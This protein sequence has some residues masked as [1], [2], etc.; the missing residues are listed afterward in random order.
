MSKEIKLLLFN[1]LIITSVSGVYSQTA[2]PSDNNN[3]YYEIDINGPKE[4]LNL[5]LSVKELEFHNSNQ[6]EL[7]I[8]PSGGWADYTYIIKKNNVLITPTPGGGIITESEGQK[9]ITGLS[10][11]VYEVELRDDK[12]SS[13]LSCNKVVKQIE[14][15]NPKLLEINASVNLGIPCNGGDGSIKVIVKGG[16]APASGNYTIKLYK[17]SG[18]TPVKTAYL[19]HSKDTYKQIIFY[20]LKNG[21][22]KVTVNDKYI[23]KFTTQNL[24]QPSVLDLPSSNIVTT[25]V[26]CFGDSNGTIKVT[27]TGGTSPYK[28]FLNGVE[29]PGA[30]TGTKIIN[31]KKAANNYTILI[32]DGNK[33][34]TTL[35]TGITIGGPSKELSISQI[36]Q[37]NTTSTGASDGFVEYRINGGTSGYTYTFKGTSLTGVNLSGSIVSDGGTVKFEGL[38]KDNYIFK[39]VDKTTVCTKSKAVAITDPDVLEINLTKTD[40]K[41]FGESTGTITA[42]VKGGASNVYKYKWYKTTASGSII[43]TLSDTGSSI[44]KGVGYYKVEVKVIYN[45]KTVETK[46]SNVAVIDQPSENL[47]IV[48]IIKNVSCKGGND[49]EIN[50]TNV[51]G[52]TPPY[53]YLWSN[54]AKTKNISG[55]SKG[56]YKVVV[57]DK[58]GCTLEETYTVGEPINELTITLDNSQDPLS[59]NGTDGRINVSVTG[60]NGTYT[61]KWTNKLGVNVGTSQDLSGVGAGKYT[62]VVTDAKGCTD[63]LVE[64]PLNQPD[65]LVPTI[66]IPSDGVLFCNGDNDGKLEVSVVGGLKPY[67]YHWYEILSNGSKSFLSGKTNSSV[68]GLSAGKYGIQITDRNGAGIK[69]FDEITLN[70]PNKVVLGTPTITNVK[71]KGQSTGAIEINAVGGANNYT[72]KWFKE[73]SSVVFSTLKKIENQKAG[74]YKV[75]VQD[76]NNC[77]STP[78]EATI[79]ITEPLAELSISGSSTTDASGFGLLNGSVNVTVS[80]G[81]SPY[82]YSLKEKSTGI[83]KGTSNNVTGLAGSVSGIVYE[84][85]ITDSQ[86]CKLIKEYTIYQPEKLELSL[87]LNS[88]IRCNGEDGSIS[89]TVTG[90]FLTAGSSYDYKWY[91]KLNLT[92]VIGTGVGLTAKAGDYRL[93]VEDSKGNTA[94]QDYKL[95]ENAEVVLSYTK[96]DVNCYGGNDGSIDLTVVG[97]TGVYTYIWSNGKKTQDLSSITKGVYKVVVSDENGCT[98]EVTVTISE[99][100][101]GLSISGSNT[102]DASGF[103]LLNGSV[104]VTVSGGTPPYTYSLKEK[105]TGVEKGTSNNVTGLAGSVSGIVYEMTIT[106][107]QGCKLIKEYT[108]YQP[109][110][111]ELSLSLNSEIRCNGEDGSISSTV[112][113]GFLTAGSSYDYKWYNK[114][115]LTKVIGTGVGLTT[116]A[117]DYRLIVEDSKGNTAFQDYKLKENAEVVLS[118]TKTDVNC[119]GGND[120]S[121]DLTVVGGTGVYTYIWSNGKKTQ[122]LSNITKGVYKVVV[123]DENGCRKEETITITE[124]DEYKI[125]TDVFRRPTGAG[126]SDGEITVSV[127]GGTKPYTFKWEN[128]KGNIISTTNSILNI[129][130]GI[131]KLQVLDKKGCELNQVFNLGEPEKL[132]ISIKETSSIQCHGDLSG[133]LELE[134]T[135]GVG[136]NTYTWYNATTNAVIGNTVSI[137]NLGAES[138]YVKVVDANGIDAT[139]TVYNLTEPTLLTATSSFKNLSCF[140]SKDGSIELSVKGGT[141]GYFYRIKKGTNAY[142]TWNSFAS[143]V[144]IENLSSD[145]YQ[146]Q[147]KDSND[148]YLTESGGIKVLDF[149]I[150]QPLLLEVKETIT[151]VSGFGLSNG[152]I[153]L[154]VSGGTKPYVYSWTDVSGTIVSLTKDLLN[155]KAGTYTLA[156]R[157][158]NNCEVNVSYKVNEPEKLLISIKETSSI[159]CHGDLSGVLELETTGGVGGNTYTWYNATTNAVIGNTVSISNLGAESYYVKVVDANGIDATSTVYNLT[160][161]TLLTA[162]SSFK[163]LSCFESKDG[164]IELS[165]KGGT[166]GYFYRIKKGTNA[167][168]TWN[169]FASTVSIENLS[170]DSYQVQIKD[171]N[172]CYLTES[173]GIKV[174]DFNITQ[175]LLLEVKETI[176]DVSGFGLSNGKIALNVSG[177]TK[178]YVYSWTDVS[179]TIVSLTKDLL[180]VKAGTYTLALRDKNNCEVNVSYKVNEPDKLLVN[181]K[182][183]NIVFC[184]GDKGASIKSI[185]AGGIKPYNYFWYDSNNT[186]LSNGI[187]LD[188]IGIGSY[189]LQVTDSKGNKTKSANIVVSQPDVLEVTIDGTPG[190]CGTDND[191]LITANVTGGTKP[192]SYF[193]STGAKTKELKNMSLGSYFVVITDAN[194]CKT[195]KNIVLKNPSPLKVTSKVTNVTCYNTCTGKVEL[196]VEGGLAPYNIVWNTGDTG[197]LITNACHGTYTATITDKKGCTIVKSIIVKNVEEF[198]FDIVPDEVTLC[199]GETI[200]YDVTMDGVSKYTWTSDNGF[201]S[202]KSIVTLSEGGKYTLT[203]TT[204]EGCLVSRNIEIF[205]SDVKID[206]QLILTS[207]AFVNED[208]VII[209]VSNPISSNTEWKI[210]SNVTI[211]QKTIEGLVLRFP[212]PGNYDLSLIATEGNCKKIATKT[213]NVL[214][215]RDLSDVGDSKNPFIK[216][217]EVYSNPNK[218]KFKVDVELEKEAEISLRLYSLSANTVIV[219][220]HLKGKKEYTIEYDMNTSVGVYVLLLETPKGKRIRKVIIK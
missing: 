149:N 178:P 189:Y 204:K 112:T 82:T 101:A 120:G 186:L 48:K 179:G 159:Q 23:Q 37:G 102:T 4:K 209:N 138:Y 151:D 139:S 84:M 152:K 146:V 73:G 157:D 89:S 76:I 217:F 125:V 35:K 156:L 169:S 133:V 22:Y 135:G 77:P 79:T 192:Y 147:I 25:K 54:N 27:P 127:I 96:T 106:D 88:E 137:S 205:K 213:V 98:K 26:T 18:T 114:L 122:D 172:D 153:A 64:V 99:P 119:Y 103:G 188:N 155:V 81:T 59:F 39:I 66:N 94:F 92:K 215:A 196:E 100:T 9:T 15:K 123:S 72:Y 143:T 86:G 216:E 42:A 38:K 111:L 2:D 36:D 194:G 46:T 63:T 218:G 50:L 176:T 60:G 162:T 87:S 202:N 199:S 113:G 43:S 68:Q 164:S 191:W 163:N 190:S 6:G 140:E 90:G 197:K 71:C 45:S 184:N 78:L 29:V 109:E 21:T 58:N 201:T 154:N 105:S 210:P 1:L 32:E 55:L 75:L 95:K 62:L 136:G 33:C 128:D 107:S 115:N 121:I 28:V 30:F 206:A 56:N 61:Y 85:T 182:Q 132:L 41:C 97:G 116:K 11:G 80:G 193:W 167:Y 134:T 93:I 145:S 17:N 10:S 8:V 52:G 13:G 148:C 51:R 180:N 34:R 195:N 110:K 57:T 185:V 129:P 70:E 131:Y 31:G 168:G 118:Y 16:V 40:V 160:E 158:K 150:T 124:P 5:G 219:D 117:G 12:Y 198:V 161:P 183:D 49:G 126:L 19:A 69:A 44:T 173:G 83:E 7:T 47:S 67:K 53:L 65:K 181:L 166:G 142:G 171:S 74:K 130:A 170:S 144:S 165:V 91:N 187:S 214:K 212:A 211:V 208:I 220:K 207:Q 141:G 175:P 3:I 14:L 20:N 104:N 177:G 24:S 200:E 108:I 203:V 174:L